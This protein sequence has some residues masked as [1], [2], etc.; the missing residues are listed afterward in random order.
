MYRRGG[1]GD[2]GLVERHGNDLMPAQIADIANFY[3]DVVARLPLNVER[4]VVSVGK[5]V[6]AVVDTKRDR[7]AAIADRGQVREIVAEVRSLRI[8]RGRG[9]DVG[10][11]VGEI[12]ACC[13]A[14][15]SGNV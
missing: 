3:G 9:R 4:V 1:T 6:L 15:A 14:V 2:A 12:A 10:V 7:L 11:R 8:D 5:R 13:R